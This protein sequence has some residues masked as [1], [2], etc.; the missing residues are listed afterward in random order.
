M[1]KIFDIAKPKVLFASIFVSSIT[2]IIT[3]NFIY[4]LVAFFVLVSLY[5][6]LDSRYRERETTL[7]KRSQISQKIPI[8]NDLKITPNSYLSET[9][10]KFKYE[11]FNFI[12]VRVQQYPPSFISY[13]LCPKC[14]GWLIDSV[15]KN[16]PFRI[17]IIFKCNSCNVSYSS[18]F[19]KA[20]LI[21]D[22]AK[23]FGLNV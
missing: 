12:V 5:G 14:E 6:F 3:S 21:R 11:G 13:P 19:T 7:E 10:E 15:K 1:S 20:E 22:V 18:K 8:L 17:S 9:I 16:F 2:F 4:A 23:N